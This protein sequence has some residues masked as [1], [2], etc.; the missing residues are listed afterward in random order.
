MLRLAK[1]AC[2]CG[3]NTGLSQASL[4]QIFNQFAA[5]QEEET[6]GIRGM[7]QPPMQQQMMPVVVGEVVGIAAPYASLQQQV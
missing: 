1:S 5:L 2:F 7:Q 3:G 4:E 6:A